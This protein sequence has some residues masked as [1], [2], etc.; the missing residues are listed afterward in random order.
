MQNFEQLRIIL[1]WERDNWT[2]GNV[3]KNRLAKKPIEVVKSELE[4]LK[5]SAKDVSFEVV[6]RGGKLI[7]GDRIVTFKG[8]S[9]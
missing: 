6:P 7:G 4:N 2:L 9:R 8:G 5:Q 3:Y 1:N